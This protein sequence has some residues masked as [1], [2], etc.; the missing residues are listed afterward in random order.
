MFT[1][2]IDFRLVRKTMATAGFR[3]SSHQSGQ[4]CRQQ[5]DCNAHLQGQMRRLRPDGMGIE[6]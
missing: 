4:S 6:R 5:I 1:P 3:L 2:G